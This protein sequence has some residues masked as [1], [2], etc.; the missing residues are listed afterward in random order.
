MKNIVTSSN[1]LS[2]AVSTLP[3]GL[4][5]LTVQGSNILSGAVSGLPPRWLIMV[6]LSRYDPIIWPDP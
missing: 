1:I 2:G 5:Y 3:T 4:T 6:D